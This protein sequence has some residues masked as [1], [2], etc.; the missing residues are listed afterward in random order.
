MAYQDRFFDAV[1]DV[2]R[3]VRET[4]AHAIDAA[5]RIVA[6]ALQDGGV[7]AVHDTGHLLQHEAF[8]RA[9]GLVAL[10]PFTFELKIEGTALHRT[11]RGSPEDLTQLVA[12]ALDSGPLQHGDV[13]LLNSNS[14]RAEA[15]IEL[16]R[17]CRSRGIRTI[18]VC[19]REQTIACAALHSSGLK[20]L[21]VVDVLIDNGGPVGDALVRVKGNDAMG[22]S[23]GIASAVVLWAV[24]AAAVQHLEEREVKPTLYRSVHTHGEQDIETQQQRYREQGI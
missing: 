18:G 17:Q 21:D 6:D 14:G 19:S 3:R 22:P 11:N 24:Q 1:A 16:A 7:W 10:I 5:G 4:Q 12:L 20:L 15:L 23:S 2:L 9:G 8:I 13:L